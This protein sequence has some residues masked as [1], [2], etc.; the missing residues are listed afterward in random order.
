MFPCLNLACLK[1]DGE[2][3]D[4]F[5]NLK[6]KFRSKAL[7]TES[8]QALP[9]SGRAGWEVEH[10]GI[11]LTH[12]GFELHDLDCFG[13]IY[14]LVSAFWCLSLEHLNICCIWGRKKRGE[15]FVMNLL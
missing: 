1:D 6:K 12:F 15:V 8:A 2:I 11:L 4:E 13:T 5:G 14:R 10:L 3:Y 7:H 9:G